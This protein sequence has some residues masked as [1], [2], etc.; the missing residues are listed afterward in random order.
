VPSPGG[1]TCRTHAIAATHGAATASTMT[2]NDHQFCGPLRASIA[3]QPLGRKSSL[4]ITSRW[5]C[6]VPS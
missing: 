5:I 4:A 3:A 1:V 2:S 6:E